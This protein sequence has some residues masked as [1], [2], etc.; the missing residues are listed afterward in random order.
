MIECVVYFIANFRKTNLK[1]APVL[2][3]AFETFFLYRT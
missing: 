2:S 1:Y 3:A